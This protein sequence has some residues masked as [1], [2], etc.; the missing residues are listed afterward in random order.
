M[1]Y[2]KFSTTL[3]CSNSY[4]YNDGDATV[5]RP[6]S[7]I[8]IAL[9]AEKIS[10]FQICVIQRRDMEAPVDSSCLETTEVSR[11]TKIR[12]GLSSKKA[13]FNPVVEEGDIE[14]LLKNDQ[15]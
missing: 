3:N 11:K 7:K 15:R 9:K 5:Q 2:L 1:F 6:F 12:L 10:L 8:N 13:A 4:N 14:E